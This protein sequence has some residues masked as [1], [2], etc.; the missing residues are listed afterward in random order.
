MSRKM[1]GRSSNITNLNMPNTIHMSEI[2]VTS[3]HRQNTQMSMVKDTMRLART[4]HMGDPPRLKYQHRIQSNHQRYPQGSKTLGNQS[5]VS[6]NGDT[7]A[8]SA[9]ALWIFA[10]GNS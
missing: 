5:S 9:P 10:D 8:V 4:C 7:R 1:T 2:K 3:N 6:V